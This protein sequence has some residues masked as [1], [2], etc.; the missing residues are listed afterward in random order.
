MLLLL[1]GYLFLMAWL[2]ILIDDCHYVDLGVYPLLAE[3]MGIGKE[4]LF[5]N[6][7]AGNVLVPPS[8]Q[9]VE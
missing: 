3:Y 4:E 5:V 6:H 7:D 8:L 2:R 9:S 1:Q